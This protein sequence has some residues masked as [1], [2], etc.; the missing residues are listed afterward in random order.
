MQKTQTVTIAGNERLVPT[1]YL[2]VIFF[3]GV[4][5]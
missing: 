5:L 2:I 3:G 4:K 1:S